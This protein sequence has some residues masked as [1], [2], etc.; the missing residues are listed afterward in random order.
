MS[1]DPASSVK[2]TPC[3]GHRSGLK[4]RPTINSDMKR[5]THIIALSAVLA[6]MMLTGC[7]KN[8][9]NALDELKAFGAIDSDSN[10]I[11]ELELHY[12]LFKDGKEKLTDYP[13][14]PVLLMSAHVNN[15][16]IPAAIITE[17]VEGG[18]DVNATDKVGFTALSYLLIN[19]SPSVSTFNALL[20]NGADPNAGKHPALLCCLAPEYY[21]GQLDIIEK[22]VAA[23][24]DVNAGRNGVDY[25]PLTR[26]INSKKPLAIIEF[27][28]KK[29]ANVNYVPSDKRTPLMQA[30]VNSCEANLREL[31]IKS[32]ADV[33]ATDADG[34]TPL[35]YAMRYTGEAA[36]QSYLD[37]GADLTHTDNNGDTV[38]TFLLKHLIKGD[39][40]KEGVKPLT[41]AQNETVTKLRNLVFE[42]QIDKGST[43]KTKVFDD[44]VKAYIKAGSF[45]VVS[46]SSQQVGNDFM[47]HYL[48]F[49]RGEEDITAYPFMA[50]LLSLCVERNQRA[51]LEEIKP[52][53]D[54][55]APVDA[56]YNKHSA[57]C[58]ALKSNNENV[59]RLLIE[60]GANVHGITADESIEHPLWLAA[61]NGNT[62]LAK[63]LVEHGANP[64]ALVGDKPLV[65]QAYSLEAP[66]IAR[67][68]LA[69][70]AAPNAEINGEPMLIAFLLDANLTKYVP[71]LLEHGADPNAKYKKENAT[72]LGTALAKERSDA[73]KALIE[74]GADINAPSSKYKITPL[75]CAIATGQKEIMELL[76]RSGA[77]KK[78]KDANGHSAEDYMENYNR[79]ELMNL[80]INAAEQSAVKPGEKAA[81]KAVRQMMN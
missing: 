22:L 68:L 7:S 76:L 9:D 18:V 72:A 6:G 55:G 41:A 58:Y 23:G 38:D 53:I 49:Q 60:N 27:L 29:G 25:S 43:E 45:N 75:M 35:F 64:D 34:R 77:D 4:N 32:K 8:I 73:A 54:A 67:T 28:I 56:A 46:E 79:R 36:L 10:I 62:E 61:W 15:K 57:L 16:E 3:C 17:L 74:H 2:N 69:A 11:K 48:A 47:T 14:L 78:M 20:E 51:L 80:F 31:L 37:A 42:Q 33:N 63:Y 40:F 21:E 1:R 13:Y 66:T 44:I 12:R 39:L 59:A 5:K 70:G 26:A 24:A 52:F 50:N 19:E 30:E 65:A 71:E 81:I